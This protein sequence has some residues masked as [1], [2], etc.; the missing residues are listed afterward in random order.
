MAVTIISKE[1][2]ARRV[3]ELSAIRLD[4]PSTVRLPFRKTDV[5]RYTRDGDDLLIHLN[6]GEIIRV[7]N[8]YVD[9]PSTRSELQFVDDDGAIAWLDGEGLAAAL[10]A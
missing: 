6:S 2:G 10:A 8:Y 5:D 9:Q 7:E 1:D 4:G 3:V